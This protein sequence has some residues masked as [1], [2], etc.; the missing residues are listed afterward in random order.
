[1]QS[2]VFQ[3][4]KHS[5][6]NHLDALGYTVLEKAATRDSQ[7]NNHVRKADK[8]EVQQLLAPG[9]LIIFDRMKE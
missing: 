9:A 5:S 6:S 3:S 2:V 4:A 8:E 7:D 1:V